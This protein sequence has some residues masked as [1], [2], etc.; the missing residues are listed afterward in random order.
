MDKTGPEGKG[1]ASGRKLGY[2]MN[3]DA[4]NEIS[5]ILGIGLGKRFHAASGHFEGKG[6]RKKYF[7]DKHL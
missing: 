6:K 2:C 5:G 1:I 3:P 7:Q 4:K